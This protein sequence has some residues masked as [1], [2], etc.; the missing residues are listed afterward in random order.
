[1][2]F[3]LASSAAG[4]G[5]YLLVLADNPHEDAAAVEAAVR[6]LATQR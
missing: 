3:A 2:D 1:V 5:C 6:L 4:V